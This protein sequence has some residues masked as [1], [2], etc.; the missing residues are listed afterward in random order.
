MKVMKLFGLS[1]CSLMASWVP[2]I[3]GTVPSFNQKESTPI[4]IVVDPTDPIDD[5]RSN[6]PFFAELSNDYVLLGSSTSCGTVSVRITST[7][8]DDYSTNFDT[9]T[10]VILLPISGE[11]GQYTLTILTAEGVRYIGEFIL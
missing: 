10:G 5:P 8:G 2:G 7:A 6:N 9:S 1:I 3:S 11:S 4:I